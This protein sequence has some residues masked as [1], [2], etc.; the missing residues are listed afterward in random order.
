MKK[1]INKSLLILKKLIRKIFSKKIILFVW[2][3]LLVISMLFLFRSQ[4]FAAWVNGRPIYRRSLTKE[5][6]KQGG[7]QVLEG[8]I[9]EGLIRSE[10]S[11]SK[12]DVTQEE[13]DA[14]INRIE[15]LIKAQGLTLDEALGFRNQTRKDLVKQIQ[16]QII[17]EKII[18]PKIEISD[19][20]LKDYFDTNKSLFGANPVFDKVK[21]QVEEQLFQQKLS[22]EY[23]KW[24]TDLKTKAKILYFIK[25]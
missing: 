3:P 21:N 25:L 8:L 14:E 11:K 7:K 12:I 16:I 6:E 17:V 5:L 19:E 20:E 23:T 13:I 4:I 10:A 18:G 24:I 9:E 2:L 22:E 15:E 1:K